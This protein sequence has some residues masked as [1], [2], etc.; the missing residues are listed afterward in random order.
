MK[1]ETS[2]KMKSMNIKTIVAVALVLAVIGAGYALA[3]PGSGNSWAS[4]TGGNWNGN[5]MMGSYGITGGF[6]GMMGNFG[7]GIWNGMMGGFRGNGG[8]M[9]GNWSG[10]GMMGYRNGT[11]VSYR[12][13]MGGIWSGNGMMGY[14]NR[15]GYCGY[16]GSY[17]VNATP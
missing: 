9:G 17:G 13:M 15:N 16:A 4:M 14:G 10:N 11:I 7:N 3:R 5:V 2:K 6:N 8:M 1:N 12:G